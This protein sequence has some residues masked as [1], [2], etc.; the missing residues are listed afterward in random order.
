MQDVW[1][2]HKDFCSAL[3]C[4]HGLVPNLE[5]QAQ[6]LQTVLGSFSSF[7]SPV[8]KITWK[9]WVMVWIWLI[10]LLKEELLFEGHAQGCLLGV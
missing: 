4:F 5:I 10:A 3:V 6:Y 8:A 2:H 9:E 1:I 7:M